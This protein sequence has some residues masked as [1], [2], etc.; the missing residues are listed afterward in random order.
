MIHWSLEL[1][2]AIVLLAIVITPPMDSI[3]T[4]VLIVVLCFFNERVCGSG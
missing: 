1:A 2:T 4:P 3:T